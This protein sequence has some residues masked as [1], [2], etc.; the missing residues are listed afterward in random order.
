ML[1][2]NKLGLCFGTKGDHG[3]LTATNCDSVLILSCGTN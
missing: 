2:E 1:E 3:I